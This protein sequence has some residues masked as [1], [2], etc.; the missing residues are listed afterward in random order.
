MTTAYTDIPPV[1]TLAVM[2]VSAL[3]RYG[4]DLEGA[5]SAG[6]LVATAV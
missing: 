5:E 1:L 6:P 3:R 2:Q 4:V